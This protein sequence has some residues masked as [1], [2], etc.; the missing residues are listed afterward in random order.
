MRTLLAVL[1]PAVACGLVAVPA[2]AQDG[3]T[4][5]IF[6]SKTV[7]HIGVVVR[8]VETVGQVYADVF[9]VPVSDVVE[10]AAVSFPETHSGD[11][12]ARPRI[13]NVQFDNMR[14]ELAEP[15]GG[16][17]PWRDFLNRHGEGI[18]H[19]GISV[20]DLEGHVRL[21]ESLGGR[22]T[23][24]AIGGSYAF[25]DL[26]PQL[27][28][29][30]ELNKVASPLP[31]EGQSVGDGLR[32]LARIGMMA[33][34]ADPFRKAWQTLFDVP[35]APAV[36]A[37]NVPMPK[38]FHYAEDVSNREQYVPLDNTWVNVIEANGGK[39]PWRDLLDKRPGFHYL[40]FNVDDVDATVRMLESKG[41]TRTLGDV[42]VP[43]AYV[44]VPP[45]GVTIL[46]LGPQISERQRGLR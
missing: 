2:A 41:G 1:I 25:V 14:V 27:G 8:D 11:P 7:T 5:K 43:F 29:T 33:E 44:D 38:G 39:S 20:T 40:N 10:P 16:S 17:S 26:M 46:L 30:I 36:V 31:A 32:V 21:L 13:V 24:G 15:V 3:P 28:I 4:P 35:V 18:H 6:T 9:G 42:G 45:L 12:K 34:E 22:R 19:I 37:T 23:L